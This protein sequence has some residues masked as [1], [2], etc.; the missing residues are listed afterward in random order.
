MLGQ[1]W[2]ANEVIGLCVASFSI[3]VVVSCWDLLKI[4]HFFSPWLASFEFFL[5]LFVVPTE[6]G[7]T[8][9]K[10][11]CG[12]NMLYIMESTKDLFRLPLSMS[13]KAGQTRCA[14]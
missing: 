6:M 11:S 2:R 9:L 3:G 5:W 4:D 12:F 7:G 1:S 13:P 14:S 8:P 10:T